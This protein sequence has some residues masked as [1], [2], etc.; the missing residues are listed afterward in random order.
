M[1]RIYPTAAVPAS[2]YTVYGLF[3]MCDLSFK[4]I[5]LIIVNWYMPSGPKMGKMIIYLYIIVVAL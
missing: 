2:S 5:Y 1:H 4:N 3:C